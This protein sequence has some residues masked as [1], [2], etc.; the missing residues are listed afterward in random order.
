MT[1]MVYL[2]G[3]WLASEQAK[4]SVFDRGFLFSDG[5]Y[6]VVPVYQG[7]P[8]LLELHLQRLH[9]SLTEIGI[10]APTKHFWNT[11]VDELIQRNAAH[12]CLV[13]IQ[14][15][16]G[17]E[18]QRSHLP[19]SELQPTI[20]ACV[21]SLQVHWQVPQPVKVAV[22]EDIRWQRCDIKSISLLGN[23][24]LKREAAARGALEP[25]LHRD[26]RITE[27][28]SCNYFAVHQGKLLTPPAD[29]LI[30]S[31][32]T[33]TWVL[34]L[35]QQLQIETVEEPIYVNQLHHF[36]ELFLT[37]SSREVQPVGQID[38][39]IVGNGQCGEVTARLAEAFHASKR[40]LIQE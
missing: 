18:A 14:V 10:E 3:E 16:M 11:L 1:T 37:S 35:A 12:D 24:M 25:L 19:S 7:H 28:A 15:T 20:F 26:G 30:L 2:N 22:L 9:R 31:G 21:S 39:I 38:D 29:H 6:E 23:I 40:H 34:H 5:I 17:A 36:D 13:Y 8:F 4:V 32:I 33:R 27:G